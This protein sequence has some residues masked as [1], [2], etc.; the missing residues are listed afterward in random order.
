M[1]NLN[2]VNQ[3]LDWLS[4]PAAKRPHVLTLYFPNVDSAGHNSGPI[5]LAV[6]H[7]VEQVDDALGELLDGVESLPYGDQIALVL[8]SDH[9]MGQVDPYMVD[10]LN[11]I[12]NLRDTTIILTG[13]HANVFVRPNPE[14]AHST[15]DALNN[16]LR[17][18]RAYLRDE[19]PAPLHYRDN[20]RI[21]DVVI[22][23]N[24]GAMM[25]VGTRSRPPAGMHGWDPQNPEI[26]GVFLAAGPNIT[27]GRRIGPVESIHVYP[28]LTQLLHLTPNPNIDGDVSVLPP[29]FSGDVAPR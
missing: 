12:A 28:F 25:N 4:L 6:A 23:A 3:A 19:V 21:G 20:P 22:I 1:S 5:S 9:G 15:R 27:A 13:P 10:N 29:L 11:A 14:R 16:G 18:G 2:R 17:H 24:P 7:A 26:H 8:V